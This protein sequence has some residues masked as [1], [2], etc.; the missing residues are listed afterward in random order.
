MSGKIEKYLNTIM[1]RDHNSLLSEFPPNSVHLTVT[2]PPYD[3][4]RD[5]KG[6]TFDHKQLAQNLYRVT[7]DGGVVVWVVK[8]S[9]QDGGKS[10]TSYTQAIDF[11]NTGFNLYDVIIYSK[12][13]GAFS[14]KNRYCDTFEY[15]FVFS[16]G[17]PITTNIIK[18]K[19]NK[20]FGEKSRGHIR[21]KD[22]GL[23]LRDR[24]R[25]GKYS[26][27]YNIWSYATGNM[28]S[29]KD[30]IAFEHPAIFPEKIAR[31]HI[32]SWSNEGDVVL[33]PMSGS[34][35]V[36]KMAYLMNRKYI[37]IDISQKYCDIAQQR[38]SIYQGKQKEQ[39]YWERMLNP[40]KFMDENSV[41]R[42]LTEK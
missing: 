25:T 23:T 39:S 41:M 1:C 16:K 12:Y 36:P 13:G 42:F 34:G 4:L 37:G 9:V 3:D 29:T 24:K 8:D 15:M 6:Y 5:Y 2:S 17:F 33:D 19:V 26:N 22:G 38:L 28:G 30:K 27:R 20:K 7:I 40:E 31:D 21:R 18:D 11:V 10:M 14:H 35:T 32:Y